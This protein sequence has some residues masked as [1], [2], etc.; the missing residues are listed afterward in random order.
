METKEIF[1]SRDVEFVE[2]VYPFAGNDPAPKDQGDHSV[3]NFEETIEDVTYQEPQLD[4]TEGI[5][6]DRVG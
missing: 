4:H 5:V 1:I 6:D 3:G 2:S